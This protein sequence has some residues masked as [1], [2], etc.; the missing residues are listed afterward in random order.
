MI[1][2]K[3]EGLHQPGPQPYWN[4]SFYFNFMCDKDSPDDTPWGGA[5]RIGHSPNQGHRDGFIIFYFPDG[6][7]G[8]IRYCDETP[9]G[10]SVANPINAQQ[11]ELHCVEAFKCWRITYSGPIYVFDDAKDASNF[12]KITLSTLPTREVTIDLTFDCYH[13]PFDFH[14]AMK[15]RGISFKRLL[16]KLKPSYLFNHIALAVKKLASIRVMGGASHYEQAGHIN[17]SITVNGSNHPFKG[18]G[19]RDH[20]WGVRDMRVITNW[21]WFS[22]Q[23]GEDLAFNATRVEF[24]GFQAIGGHAYYQGQCHP[25]KTWSLEANYDDTGKWANDF[26]LTLTLENGTCLKIEGNTN[27]NFPVLHTT[28]GLTAQV[29]EGLASF[30]WNGQSSTGISEFMGQIYP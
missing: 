1:T 23:F 20:S 2:E 15:I 3:D 18:T 13:P 7:A 19:Q 30:R 29:N 25:L 16:E 14:R 12:H 24:L 10:N 26:T 5:I 17:G 27:T 8:F 9:Y 11:I 28:K 4:E 21:Q 6:K 22:C